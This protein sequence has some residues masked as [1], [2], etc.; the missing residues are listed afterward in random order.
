MASLTQTI[1]PHLQMSA[2]TVEQKMVQTPAMEASKQR[3]MNA[4][5]VVTSF[6]QKV[7]ATFL[8][9]IQLQ[10]NQERIAIHG[11][12]HNNTVTPAVNGS[13]ATKTLSHDYNKFMSELWIGA[14]I[15]MVFLS[16]IF[17]GC[18]CL[19]YHQLRAWNSKC[20]YQSALTEAN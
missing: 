18:T 6:V 11:S 10:G 7:G 8:Q 19:L 16:I 4:V 20:E 2:G 15:T 13:L 14:V 9:S 3:V 17:C 5:N 1:L 12:A